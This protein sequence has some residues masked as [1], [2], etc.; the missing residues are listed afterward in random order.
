MVVPQGPILGQLLFLIHINDLPYNLISN[1]K[2][3]AGDTSIFSIINDI[4]VS[5]EEIN[6]DLKRISKRAYQWKMMFNPDLTKQ[7]QEVTF[8][9]K[10]VKPFHSRV[11]F[12]EVPVER[13]V[14]QKHLGLHLDQKLDFSKHINEK[15]SKV[16]KVISVIKKLY[17][18][19]PRNALL[20]IYKSLVQPHLDSGD[21]VFDQP[22]NQNFTNKIEAVRY[23]AALEITNTIKGTSKTKL[24][25]EFGIE[26]LSFRQ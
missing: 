8:Y 17:N 5:T 7:P 1:V 4:I 21:I 24:Y 6:N 10:T 15:I 3:F 22:N 25:K 19:L 26:S 12:N 20:T 13:S 11:F 18:I 2:L 14:S 9:R 23:N 16:Q